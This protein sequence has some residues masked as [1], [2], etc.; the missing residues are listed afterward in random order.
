MGPVERRLLGFNVGLLLGRFGRR[1]VSIW[2]RLWCHSC[3]ALAFAAFSQQENG[4]GTGGHRADRT[5]TGQGVFTRD[6]PQAE[7]AAAG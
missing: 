1:M 6:E 4:T 3:P 2:A 7:V 5:G